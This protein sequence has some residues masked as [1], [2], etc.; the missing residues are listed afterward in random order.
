[1]ITVFDMH[2]MIYDRVNELSSLTYDH[3]FPEQVDLAINT[4]IDNFLTEKEE[5][6]RGF[7]N[8]MKQLNELL[9][10]IVSEEKLTVITPT[11]FSLPANYRFY[12]VAHGT[13][14]NSDD[15]IGK[16]P[17]A[18]LDLEY[19]GLGQSNSLYA[20]DVDGYFATVDSVGVRLEDAV[21]GVTLED[22]FL[23]YVKQPTYV[24]LVMNAGEFDAV[25]SKSSE[26]PNEVLRIIAERAAIRINTNINK[27]DNV[28]KQ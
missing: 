1:M 6:V 21:D 8:R 23:T 9:P 26:L 27:S 5:A 2:L 3:I 22:I 25:V 24:K 19:K 11:T 16:V 10:L 18:L 7:S 12:A 17:I 15:S 4:E 28:K 13:I 14:R 20:S